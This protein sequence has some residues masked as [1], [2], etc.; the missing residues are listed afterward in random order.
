MYNVC[1][2]IMS[3]VICIF[4]AS[5]NKTKEILSELLENLR[6]CQPYNKIK[7]VVLGKKVNCFTVL[8]FDNYLQQKIMIS[9]S[10]KQI[11]IWSESR[12]FVGRAWIFLDFEWLNW[13]NQ[14]CFHSSQWT[15]KTRDISSLLTWIFIWFQRK[16]RAYF[17]HIQVE[18]MSN[19]I[20][21]MTK[22]GLKLTISERQTS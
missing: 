15:R 16:P 11:F 14:D 2:Q 9:Q 7:A 6:D 19:G 21:V 17:I 18:P 20:I 4:T 12:S 1:N 22:V 5:G 8:L 3:W 10:S 13:L